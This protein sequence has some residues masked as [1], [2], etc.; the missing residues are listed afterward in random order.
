MNTSFKKDVVD[1]AFN[2]TQKLT[3]NK[4]EALNAVATG[5]T[6]NNLWRLWWRLFW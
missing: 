2:V 5:V 1:L 4:A 6:P 3:A